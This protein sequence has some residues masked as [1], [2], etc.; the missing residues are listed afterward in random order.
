M[1]IAWEDFSV[2]VGVDIQHQKEMDKC[3]QTPSPTENRQIY[4]FIYL[5]P[6]LMK[7]LSVKKVISLLVR[8]WKEDLSN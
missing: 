5:D 7:L 2:V 3:V 4:C 6:G 1:S 8:L